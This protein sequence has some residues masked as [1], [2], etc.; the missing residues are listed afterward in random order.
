MA[1]GLGTDEP[2]A[3][4]F[5]DVD[6]EVD[7]KVDFNLRSVVEGVGVVDLTTSHGIADSWGGEHMVRCRTH[8]CSHNKP[9]P[10]AKG[11]LGCLPSEYNLSIFLPS[12]S[13]LSYGSTSRTWR[14]FSQLIESTP[15]SG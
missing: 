2:S 14:W 6:G 15:G 10:N 13:V 1:H 8:S 7:S 12:R 4:H 11:H 3:G 9:Q 5:L